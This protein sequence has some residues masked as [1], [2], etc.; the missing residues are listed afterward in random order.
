M[1]NRIQTVV[2]LRKKVQGLSKLSKVS[3]RKEIEFT[4]KKNVPLYYRVLFLFIGDRI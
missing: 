1:G 3:N 4:N 2:R